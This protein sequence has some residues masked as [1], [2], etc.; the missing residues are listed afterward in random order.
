MITIKIPSYIHGNAVINVGGA[1]FIKENIFSPVTRSVIV[2]SHSATFLGADLVRWRPNIYHRETQRD[3][4]RTI[5]LD[6]A[7]LAVITLI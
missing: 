3:T 1:N 6:I 2:L 4:E 5:K 7:G